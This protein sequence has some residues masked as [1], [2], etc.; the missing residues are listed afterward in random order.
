[1]GLKA[2]LDEVTQHWKRSPWRVKIFLLVALF[3]ST[4]SLASLSDAV[5]KWKGF[6]L[7]AL[8]FYRE[9][10]SQPLAEIFSGVLGHPLPPSFFDGAV[11]LGLVHGALIRAILLRRASAMQHIA[12][13]AFFVFSYVA[14]L[15]I[16]GNEKHKPGES[17]SWILY[18]GFLLAVYMLTKGAE[19]MLALAY[20]V[21]PVLLVSIIAAVSAGLAK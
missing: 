20:M 6:I 1:M 19:R 16:L 21:A 14:M 8:I 4:S 9:H 7:D 3:L 15:F 12:D 17:S 18:P 10:I 11:L 5:F 2:D 13:V